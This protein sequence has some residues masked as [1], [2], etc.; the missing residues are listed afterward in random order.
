DWTVEEVRLRI[1]H[2]VGE[3]VIA[4]RQAGRQEYAR[5]VA[6]TTALQ[7]EFADG[8]RRALRPEMVRV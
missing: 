8:Q 7:V 5:V 6:G 1:V 4:E 3:W 2:E